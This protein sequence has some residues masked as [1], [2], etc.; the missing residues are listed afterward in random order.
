MNYGEFDFFSN[1]FQPS[2]NNSDSNGSGDTYLFM[3]I[4]AN[5]DITAPTKAN[6]FKTKI[7]TGNNSTQSITGAGFKPDFIWFKNRTGTN[8][9]ALVDSVRGRGSYLYSDTNTQQSG[10]SGASN[11]LVSFDSDGF[12]V[13][14]VSQAGSTNTSGGSI[15]AW[16]WKALDHDRNLATINNDGNTSSIVSANPEAGFS[17]VK[18]ISPGVFN[19]FAVGHGLSSAPQLIIQKSLTSSSANNYV[20]TN[21]IDGSGDY[22]KLDTND[23]KTDITGSATSLFRFDPKT[24]TD[25]WSSAQTVINYCFHSVAGYSSIGTY[26]GNG[27]TTGPSITVGFRPSWIITKNASNTGSWYIWDAVR[28]GSTTAF[29]KLLYANINNVEYLSLIHI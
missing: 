23:A 21:A 25:W 10:A 26:T 19:Q 29:P 8:S 18:Y 7:Y 14:S 2:N 12:T 4:A 16:L 22:L 27:S 15:V 17:I 5:P 28:A 11:D 13:G 6:S 9:N 24:F 1:G 20:L 3:A